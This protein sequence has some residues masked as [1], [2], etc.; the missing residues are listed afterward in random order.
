MAILNFF[1]VQK[2]IFGHFRN[3][4]KWIL[5]KKNFVKLIYL[6]TRVFLA[7][8][9][10]NFLA[11]SSTFVY[12]FS[13]SHFYRSI[14]PKLWLILWL[15]SSEKFANYKTTKPLLTAKLLNSIPW[16]NWLKDLPCLSDWMPWKIVKLSL[17]CIK[18]VIFVYIFNYLFTFSTIC[19][20]FQLFVYIYNYL[21]TNFKIAQNF[22]YFILQVSW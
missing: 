3:F 7:W 11:H 2:L 21:F 19:L 15:S 12:K 22:Q 6:I 8:T 13:S 1:P 18:K 5:V 17:A 16:R 20:H 14:L 4:K 9:C 10:L